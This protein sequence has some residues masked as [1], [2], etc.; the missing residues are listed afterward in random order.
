MFH[1][2]PISLLVLL[3]VLPVGPLQAVDPAPAAPA[4]PDDLARFVNPFIG[5]DRSGNTYPGSVSPFGSVQL[6]PNL[7]GNGYYYPNNHMHGFVVNHMSGDGGSNEGEVLMTATTG[8]VKIDRASTDY[9][10]DHQHE[11]ASA[12]YYQVLMQPWNIDAEL[13]TTVH[14]GF[15][16]F[17]FPAGQQGNILLPLSYVNNPP[18]ISSHVRYVDSQTVEGDVDTV[19]FNGLQLGITAYFVMKFSKPFE[20]HGTWTNSTV[21][22]NSD[23]ASQEDRQTVIGFYGSYPA[24]P[25]PQEVDVRIG[26]SYV[27]EKGAEANL[28]A[29]MPDDDFEK[30]H[31]QAVQDWNRELALIETQGGTRTHNRIFYTALYHSLI[32]PQI[33]DDVDGRYRGFDGRSTRSPP[34]TAISTRLFR[35]GTFTARKFPCSP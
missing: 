35:D 3:I 29:E 21:T 33:A 25:T 5:T 26:V 17:T 10:F 14:C 7:A 19:S 30:Y 16:K 34:G 1:A 22:G 31:Q 24:A 4:A 6:T 28:A 18:S 11:S 13:T 32:A 15:A 12:G 2:S 9:Q 20:T 8:P 27:D 23:S